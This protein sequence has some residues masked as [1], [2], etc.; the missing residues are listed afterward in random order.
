MK[1]SDNED[2]EERA[3]ASADNGADSWERRKSP[4]TDFDDD[5]FEESDRDSDFNAIYTDSEDEELEL[6]EDDD[7]QEWSLAEEEAPFNNKRNNN[8][9]TPWDDELDDEEFETG[10]KDLWDMDVN[11]EGSFDD[12]PPEETPQPMTIA[13]ATYARAHDRTQEWDELEEEEEYE[14]EEERELNIS[15]GMIVVAVFALILLGAGGYGIIEERASLQE[16]IRQLRANLATSASPDEV[17]A[18]REATARASERNAQLQQRVE[19]MGRENRSLQAIISGLESQLTAQQE[20]LEQASTKAPEQ[21]AVA[22]APKPAPKAPPK[23]APKPAEKAPEKPQV[24]ASSGDWFVNFSSYSQRGAA[25]SWAGKLKPAAGKV[26]VAPAQS[27]G[28][29]IFRV[30]VIG[31]TDKSSAQAV[32]TQLQREFSTG[33]LWVGRTD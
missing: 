14:E 9:D 22:P 5:E 24:V 23:P 1:D 31:L 18:S 13:T 6:D 3:E 17:T 33:K 8:D 32:A 27:N 12:D 29:D 21:V 30:R 15:L 4:F 20:A 28:R 16:E 2:Q 19:D 25:E 11:P 10:E 7:E 26:V